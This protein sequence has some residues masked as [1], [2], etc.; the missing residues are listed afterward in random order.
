LNPTVEVI[1]GSAREVVVGLGHN[2]EVFSGSIS[3]H[4]SILGV[5][6]SGIA[7]QGKVKL[8]RKALEDS[9]SKSNDGPVGVEAVEAKSTQ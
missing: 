1:G 4:L 7:T 9:S 3:S 2:N 5:R 8:A 6:S